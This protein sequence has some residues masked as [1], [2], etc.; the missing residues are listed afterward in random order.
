[1]GAG[2]DTSS[3]ANDVKR[4]LYRGAGKEKIGTARRGESKGVE[5]RGQISTGRRRGGKTKE[6]KKKKWGEEKRTDTKQK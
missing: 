2:K 5:G 6:R 4:I 3:N 1:L